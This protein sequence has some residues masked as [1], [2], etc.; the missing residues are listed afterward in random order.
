MKKKLKNYINITLW[1][2]SALA[3]IFGY[4]V[5]MGDTIF[6]INKPLGLSFAIPGTAI[7]IMYFVAN[8]HL[9]TGERHDS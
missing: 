4:A 2:M 7:Y 3:G 1:M 8:L 5:L 6:G 9:V